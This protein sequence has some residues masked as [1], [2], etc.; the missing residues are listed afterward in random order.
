V[1]VKLRGVL[2]AGLNRSQARRG[3][4]FPA[5]RQS[6]TQVIGPVG[7]IDSSTIE[8]PPRYVAMLR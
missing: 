1:I 8:P 4:S 3:A 7:S 6:S 2:L 5:I